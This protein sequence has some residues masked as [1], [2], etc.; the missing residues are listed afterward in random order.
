VAG[1]HIEIPYAPRRLQLE[2]HS[3]L[4]RVRWGVA[5][6]HRRFGKTVCAVN[7]LQRAA[8]TCKKPRPRFAYIAPTYSQGKAISWDYMKHYSAPIPGVRAH[9]SELR[10]DY[11]MNESQVRIYGADNPD[12]LRGLYFDG[13]VLDEYG[14]MRPHLFREV[15]RPALADRQGWALFL[16]TPNGKN[17]FYDII[18]GNKDFIGAKNDPQWFFAEYKASQ[19]NLIPAEELEAAKAMMTADQYEQEFECSF[20]ASVQGAVFAREMRAAREDGRV[21]N[22]PYDPMLQ[23]DTDWDLG[24]DDSTS[25]WFS[26][27]TPGGEVR[28]IDY[29][30]ATGEGLA[31]YRE[32]LN[33]KK[34]AYGYHYA[35]HD[36]Q[37]RELGTGMSRMAVAN[38]LGLFF[39]VTPRLL[40][41]EGMELHDG[42]NAAR[43]IFRRCWFDQ[44]KC[45]RGIEALQHYRWGYNTTI[46]EFKST[47]IHDWSSHAADAF[48]G[49][50]VRTWVPADKWRAKGPREF[51]PPE[52]PDYYDE[53]RKANPRR[54]RQ[55]GRRGGY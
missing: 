4:E 14:L 26:Q 8:V 36:I 43:L 27:R 38:D 41:K 15:V 51:E 49:L 19:T 24:M 10:I 35:P 25:I 45:A 17:Q 46:N 3:A 12:S 21:T 22:V 29:Y 39:Q 54:E 34:Y 20:E 50:S 2:I 18:H 32:V 7:H 13:V 1:T 30:E 42:I 31:H 44:T 33:Q 47:P 16:G 53:L 37:V 11:P 48:R 52:K 28:L 9:E 23:V 55:V 6:C 5:V 40:S